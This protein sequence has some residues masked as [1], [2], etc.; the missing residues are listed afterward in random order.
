MRGMSGIGI[1]AHRTERVVGEVTA[2]GFVEHVEECEE[3]ASLGR[4]VRGARALVETG[5]GRETEVALADDGGKDAS[6]ARDASSFGFDEHARLPR[7][8]REGEHPSPDV[9]DLALWV[10]GV[11]A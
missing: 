10:D 11:E 7:V 5:L 4:D 6:L 8:K 3:I 9:R 1:E 2:F